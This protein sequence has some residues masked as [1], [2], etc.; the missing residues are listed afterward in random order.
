M[1]ISCTASHRAPLAGAAHLSSKSSMAGA[2][3]CTLPKAPVYTMR[4]G[5]AT[6]VA[7][8]TPP[9]TRTAYYCDNKTPGGKLQVGEIPNLIPEA[10]EVLVEVK[11]AGVN[12]LDWN[13]AG[14]MKGVPP[15]IRQAPYVAGRDV[16]GVVAQCGPGVTDFKVGDEVM[17]MTGLSD[18]LTSPALQPK[19]GYATYTTLKAANAAKKPS[20]ISFAEASAIPLAAL[21]AWEALESANVS[22]GQKVLVWGGAGGV[23]TFIIQMA[24]ARGAAEVAVTCSASSGD[25]C[26]GLGADIVVD[27]KS[28]NFEDVISG[29]DVVVDA[30]GYDSKC[31]RAKKV[32]KAGGKLVDLVTIPSIGY[33]SDYKGDSVVDYA[34]QLIKF[35]GDVGYKVVGVA[36]NGAYLRKI[37]SLVEEGKVKVVIDS[38]FSGLGEV[39]DAWARNKT[40]GAHGKI[41]IEL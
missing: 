18:S 21:T 38:T 23:G 24:K 17:G 41:V 2:L 5:R 31:E 26:K 1:M 19:G 39:E 37:A 30:V 8:A 36:Q 29:Y 13:L 11:A 12:A 25:F 10:G 27:Y 3:P 32:L 4:A 9:A 7:A 15:F 16:A 22:S 14:F 6:P 40:G 28:E 20:N 35:G 33:L 34:K